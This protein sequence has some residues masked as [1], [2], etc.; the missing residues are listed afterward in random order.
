MA[1]GG[2]SCPGLLKPNAVYIRTSGNEVRVTVD[3]EPEA[4]ATRSLSLARIRQPPLVT[5]RSAASMSS[6][7]GR[8]SSPRWTT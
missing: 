6:V 3:P 4:G 7:R 1:S 5:P 8:R 2:H